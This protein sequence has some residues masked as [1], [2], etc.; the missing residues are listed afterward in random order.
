M[1][2]QGMRNWIRNLD[3]GGPDMDK[4]ASSLKAFLNTT[5][6]ALKSHVA[7][8]DRMDQNV[9][10][11][12]ESFVYGNSQALLDRLEWNGLFTMSEHDWTARLEKLQ[13]VS[14]SHLEIGCLYN[15]SIDLEELLKQPMDALLSIDQYYSPFEKL[16]RILAVYQRVNSTLSEALNQDIS[17]DRKLP[18]ADDVLPTI[19]LTVLKA[20]PPRIFRT[21]QFVDVF[22]TQENLR[23]EAG[24]AYTNLYGAVQFLQD[25]DMEKPHFSIS[26]EEFRKGIE[27]SLSISHQ[28]TSDVAEVQKTAD[29]ERIKPDISAREVREG[30][31]KGKRFHLQWALERQEELVSLEGEDAR[32]SPFSFTLPN[33]FNRSYSFVGTRPEDVRMSDLPQLLDEYKRLANVTE[34]LLSERAALLAAEKRKKLVERKNNVEDTLIGQTTVS[35]L[36]QR[37]LSA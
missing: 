31:L 23:G 32:P 8:R 20:R 37:G 27:K 26:P 34:Q 25:L 9:R 36:R 12:M 3:D 18:S 4:T 21:L 10:R 29:I 24:Y 2:V 13:F 33:G 19:I 30:R 22:A 35:E 11:S 5:Y 28:S 16:Q 17:G 6:E 14:P 15:S 1:L 7:W